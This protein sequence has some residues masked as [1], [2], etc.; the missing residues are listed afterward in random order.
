MKFSISKVAFL[1]WLL[2]A[3]NA[4]AVTI[5]TGSYTGDGLDNKNI[6]ISPACQ[7]VA[8]F[9]QRSDAAWGGQVFLSSMSTNSSGEYTG[10]S[11]NLADRIQQMNSDGFQIGTQAY[12]N[13]SGSPYRYMAVCDNGANDVAVG[14][15][16]GNAADNRDITISP[17]FQPEIVMVFQSGS[18]FAAWRGATSHTGDSASILNAASAD[19]A[20]LIQQFNANG[21]QVGTSENAN[22]VNYYY[23]ALKGNAA[24]V[25]SGSFT[26]N[27]SDNRDITTPGFQPEFVFIKGGSA[28]KK[29]S[30]RYASQSGDLSFCADAAEA[31]N[32]IQSFISTGFQVGTD[33]CSN[34]NAVTMR[35]LAL[36]DVAVTA[37]QSMM[38]LGVGN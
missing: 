23:L 9:V 12:V 16:A 6:T 17:A 25:A 4:W 30:A 32:I 18:G 38:L 8:V 35:W 13:N 10:T 29:V 14:T 19:S 31:A 26:G 28:T 34:E 15:Y 20:N 27:G 21:F 22:T 36:A 33:T 11:Q 5:V 1:A 2:I 37:R 7:P 3:P 24:G